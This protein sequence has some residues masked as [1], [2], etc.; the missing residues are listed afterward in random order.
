M[1]DFLYDTDFDL[2][3]KD[4]DL[5]IGDVTNQAAQEVLLADKGWYAFDPMV[6]AG[7][8]NH[9]NDD[10]GSVSS[11]IDIR[12][13]LEADGITVRILGLA[14]D[15][16]QLD[17]DY[18][19]RIY[20]SQIKA[21]YLSG[22]KKLVQASERQSVFDLA[23]IYYGNIE[24]AFRIAELLDIEEFPPILPKEYL[25]IDVILN[26]TGELYDKVSNELATI[27]DSENRGIGH[28]AIGQDFIIT[29]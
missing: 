26:S 13:G 16:L 1:T 2:L 6:G 5:V 20:R 10:V 3:I 9:L 17:F 19:K 28:W 22:V 29:S 8:I 7:L 24:G 21:Y 25:T 18:N 27:L 4:G 15:K 23:L 14:S 12:R 11:L